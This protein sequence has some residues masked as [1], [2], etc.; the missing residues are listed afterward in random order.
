M[1]IQTGMFTLENNL[2]LL[3]TLQCYPGGTLLKNLPSR[4]RGRGLNPWVG[5]SLGVG[6]SNP[7]QYSCLENSSGLYSLWGCKVKHDWVAEHV[8]VCA[9]AHPHTHTH[10]HA[11]LCLRLPPYNP[12]IPLLSLY[13]LAL[14]ISY[15][16]EVHSGSNL[17]ETAR[18]LKQ[19]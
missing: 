7:L 4:A 12:A 16:E 19:P 10:T 2:A 8:C 5:N 6:N 14:C 9:R 15:M 18:I 17:S 11:I 1:R 3:T 13:I